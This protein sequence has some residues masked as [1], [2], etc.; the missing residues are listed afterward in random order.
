MRQAVDPTSDLVLRDGIVVEN[1]TREPWKGVLRPSS[2][3]SSVALGSPSPR[4]P[5]RTFAA[6]TRT[7][8]QTASPPFAPWTQL[9][10]L[11]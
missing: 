3:P 10:A 8:R 9:Q 4:S 1:C 11:L 6:S 2:G 7:I 5:P